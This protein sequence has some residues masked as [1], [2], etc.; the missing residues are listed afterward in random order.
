M[1]IGL[2]YLCLGQLSLKDGDF[3]LE[4][5]NLLKLLIL[6]CDIGFQLLDGLLLSVR[7][8]SHSHTYTSLVHQSLSDL[9]FL[10]CLSDSVSESLGV[11]VAAI[12]TPTCISF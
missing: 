6:L 4:L 9:L 3:L 8:G 12:T 5:Q 7:S 1:H 10:V 2:A 11:S